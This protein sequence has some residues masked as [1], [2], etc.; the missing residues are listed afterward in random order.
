MYILESTRN[1]VIVILA[2]SFVLSACTQSTIRL[3]PDFGVAVRQD[4]A[5]QIADP[6]AHYTGTPAPGGA[7]GSRVSLAQSRY[8]ENRVIPPATTSTQSS[9]TS[10]A[11]SSTNSGASTGASAG[12]ASQ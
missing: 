10:T 2:A 9:T 8:Q 12:P 6:D 4:V 11:G 1:A 3:D 5:S 7:D